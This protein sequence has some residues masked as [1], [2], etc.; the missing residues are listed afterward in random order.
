MAPEK[1]LIEKIKHAR[2]PRLVGKQVVIVAEIPPYRYVREKKDTVERYALA[3]MHLAYKLR[4]A[5]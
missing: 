2:H 5:Q 4:R 3:V 1:T